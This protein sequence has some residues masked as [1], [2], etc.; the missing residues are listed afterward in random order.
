MTVKDIRID[1]YASLLEA[2][3]SLMTEVYNDSKMTAAEKMKTFALGVRNDA[4]IN[5]TM[6]S[7]R[8]ELLRY[9][10]K[11]KNDVQALLFN[12]TQDADK[13]GEKA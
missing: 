3:A 2:N 12:P 8:Q 9:G 4:L 11:A 1:N 7:R 10:M 13:A 6:A 5:R